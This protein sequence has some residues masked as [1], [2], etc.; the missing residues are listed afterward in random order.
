MT[1]KISEMFFLLSLFSLGFSYAQAQSTDSCY[2]RSGT[3]SA[4]IQVFYADKLD[5]PVVFDAGG[6]TGVGAFFKEPIEWDFGDGFKAKMCRATHVY[7]NAGTYTV[8]LKVWNDQGTLS[9]TSTTVTINNIPAATGTNLLTVLTSGSGD[10]ITTFNTIQ[11]A[12]N[13]AATIN[14]SGTVEISIPAGST[15]SEN[16]ELKVPQGNN[17]ITLKSSALNNLPRFLRV[18]RS[19]LSNFA[20]I[21]SPLN[22]DNLPALRTEL[23]SPSGGQCNTSQTCLPVH[24]Y[25]F[26]GI[27]FMV[28][29]GTFGGLYEAIVQLGIDEEIQNEASEQ[30][31]HL[32]MDRALIY[33]EDY[34]T[35][36]PTPQLVKNGFESHCTRL[37]VLE[38]HISGINA[39]GVESHA[40]ATHNSTGVW[41]V[42]NS[43]FEAGGISF[44]NGGAFPLIPNAR[45]EDVEFRRNRFHKPMEKKNLP[46]AHR[47]SAKTAFETK[48]GK[49]WTIDENLFDGGW[50]GS[51]QRTLVNFNA[52]PSDTGS[53]ATVQDI[54][55]THNVVRQGPAGFLIGRVPGPYESAPFPARL[56]FYNNLFTELGGSNYGTPAWCQQDCSPEAQGQGFIVSTVYENMIL[57]HNTMLVRRS[58]IDVEGS[59]NRAMLFQD[60]IVN[61]GSIIVDGD[62]GYGIKGGGNNPGC[63]SIDPLLSGCTDVQPTGNPVYFAGSNFNKNIITGLKY[64]TRYPQNAGYPFQ[65]VNYYYPTQTPSSPTGFANIDNH[66]VNRAG[67][68]YRIAAGTPGD[69]GASDGTDVGAN[70]DLT[71]L[72]SANAVTGSWGT[73]GGQQAPYPGPGVPTIPATLEIENY[74]SGGEGVAYHDLD[75]GNDGGVYRADDVDIQSRSTAS[76]G[77]AVFS[78]KA[79]EWLEY[80]TSASSAGTFNIAVAYSSQFNNGKF[81]VEIDGVNVTGQ[82]TANST[83]SW[84]TFQTV[85]KTGVS[86]LAGQHIVRLAFDSNSPD[87]CGCVVANFDT[88]TFQPSTNNVTWQNVQGTTSTNGS[89]EHAGTHYFSMA[90]TQQTISNSG[91]FEWTYDG[92]PSFVGLGNNDDEEVNTGYFDLPYAFS[93]SVREFGV[94]KEDG[95][96]VAGDRVRIEIDANGV[97][98]YKKNGQLVYTSQTSASG[99]YYL[100]FK[101]AET[102]GFGISN[103][104]FGTN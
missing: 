33:R 84:G 61:H 39:P 73:T 95:F 47:W 79:G 5:E 2:S 91:H 55:F 99:Q 51:D 35:G 75:A 86:I 1:K 52:L 90:K 14:G 83:G 92:D 60:N 15:F 80:T 62:L 19:N 54:Q 27:Q 25:R 70:I 42:I 56:L 40:M 37:S 67:G 82:L 66:F 88:L 58:I 69:N 11:A 45:V 38:S 36:N 64:D 76:N 6:S 97:V 7:R 8:T 102:A 71:D 46:Q 21:K 104:S 3:L 96:L 9:T 18:S 20:T 74:D 89:V 63:P 87:G 43:Y 34:S 49:Y 85:T 81:H 28:D 98:R 48:N 41:S 23:K 77:Y 12:V 10:G 4:N 24:H 103:A 101:T 59:S 57:R 53:Q 31:H 78:A 16:V 30:P 29:S 100:V 72:V 44:I 94:W 22:F 65:S 13:K 17:Y 26:Q 50:I 93:G 68:N 32:I